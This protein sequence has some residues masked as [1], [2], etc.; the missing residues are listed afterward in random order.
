MIDL[1]SG[2]RALDR[3]SSLEFFSTPVDRDVAEVLVVVELVLWESKPE[4]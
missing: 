4:S 1:V 3:N 2:F